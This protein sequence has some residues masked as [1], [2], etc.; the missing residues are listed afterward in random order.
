MNNQKK[1]NS[2]GKVW[3]VLAIIALIIFVSI[4]WGCV[5]LS[6]KIGENASSISSTF[7]SV[8]NDNSSIN[9]NSE[10][11]TPSNAVGLNKN[12]K[13]AMD[14]YEETMDA[15]IAFMEKFTKSKGTNPQLFKDYSEWLTKYA[16]AVDAFKKWEN[17]NLNK[18]EAKYY[19]E[20]QTRV[21]QKL[22][23]ASI[24]MQYQ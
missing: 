2:N 22:L 14:S 12:F 17:N 16:E 9:D 23:N 15:Y 24:D 18:E 20:V 1:D 11:E 4:G 8:T 21:T 19:I 6:E 3:T 13:Q 5:L 10:S 7:T